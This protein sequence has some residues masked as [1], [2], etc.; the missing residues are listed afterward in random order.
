M[1]CILVVDDYADFRLV[2]VLM[3][4]RQPELEVVAQAGSLAEARTM[5]EGID[6]ALVDRG[7]PDGDGLARIIHEG[8]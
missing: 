7:L 4:Q 2:C 5:L 8:S 1:I 3:L 6:V